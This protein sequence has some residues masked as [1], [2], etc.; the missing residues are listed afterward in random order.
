MLRSNRLPLAV[1]FVSMALVA[2][3]SLAG[4]Q[5]AYTYSGRALGLQVHTVLPAPNTVVF[6]DT[7]ELPPA[8]GSLSASL[9][10]VVSGAVQTGP[11]ACGTQ[12]TGGAASSVAS[13]TDLSAYAGT[14]ASLTASRVEARTDATCG[15]ANASV[16]I[17]GLAVGG[18]AVTVTGAANQTVVIPG[19]G[20]LVINEQ[21]HAGIG[22]ITVNALHFTLATGDELVVCGTHSDMTCVT[23]S[24]PSTWGGIKRRFE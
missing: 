16:T 23:P 21:V 5:T 22:D 14:A 1:T 11:V 24:R 12:G 19:V 6:A 17:S 7:G 4:A 18:L 10:S 3:A 20:T 9:A 15:S 13:V 8:G 2:G